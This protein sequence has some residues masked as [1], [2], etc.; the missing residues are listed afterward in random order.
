VVTLPPAFNLDGSGSDVDSIAFWEPDDP[1][2]TLM[3]VTGKANDRLEVWKFPFVGGELAPVLFPANVNGVAIDQDADLLYVS[4]RVVTVLALPDFGQVG[5]FGRGI[6]AAGEN[7]LDLLKRADG[8]TL[9]YVSDDHAVHRFDAATH[10]LLGSFAPPVTSIETLL[11]DDF[12]QAIFVPEEQ[13]SEGATGVFVYRPD[14][15]PF[16]L[17]GSNRFG[18]GGEIDSDE[19]GILLFTF[20]SCG[21]GDDG[22]GFIVLSDQRADQTDFEV[23]DRQT[24]QH[25]GTL[26]LAGVSNTDGIASTQRP[27]PGFPRGLFAAIDDDTSTAGV[28]WDTVFAA[29]GLD[30]APEAARISPAQANPT[31]PGSLAFTVVFNEPVLGFDGESDLAVTHVGTAHAGVGIEGTDGEAGAVYRVELTG[32]TGSGSVALA[33][34]IDGGVA[35]LAGHALAFSV[36]SAAVPVRTA[37]EAWAEAAGLTAGVDDGPDDDPD[38]D[39]KPNIMEYATGNAPGRAGGSPV[40][41]GTLDDG[42]GRFLSI[43]FG[44][45]DG[46]GFASAG[47]GAVPA[48]TANVGGVRYTV[49]GSDGLDAGDDR[50]A[51]I[52]VAD[53]PGPGLPALPPG[54]SYRAF[55]LDRAISGGPAG[56]LRLEVELSGAR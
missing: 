18:D 49:S 14:G 27:M 17:D 13:G 38:R 6:I 33:V 26:R 23:Y 56:Y 21:V 16:Q 52:E 11:A 55:R 39:G 4:D 20:P 10:D 50:L 9:V 15:T 46:A 12:H 3:V 22:T 31:L 2:Q 24:W 29:I 36:T 7:N 30:L 5:E 53:R 19:E 28:G 37:F 35:D 43:T 48:L 45:L 8:R 40:A 54:W 42:G 1:E 32:I 34:R 51:V 25:L 41:V 47:G 44:V